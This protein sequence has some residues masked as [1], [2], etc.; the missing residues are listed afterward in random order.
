MVAFSSRLLRS[1]S[2]SLVTESNR[3]QGNAAGQLP[4]AQSPARLFSSR[5]RAASKLLPPLL[6]SCCISQQ[7]GNSNQIQ[8]KQ[9]RQKLG[10]V[11][12]HSLSLSLPLL[13]TFYSPPPFFCLLP[14]PMQPAG[15][16]APCLLLLLHLLLLLQPTRGRAMRLGAE[17][18]GH[19]RLPGNCLAPMGKSSSCSLA[20]VVAFP[21]WAPQGILLAPRYSNPQ[22]A[23]WVREQVKISE[24]KFH[25][26]LYS[27]SYKG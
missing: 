25:L 9:H 27:A 7:R 1:P 17:A 23:Y 5:G 21:S 18:G 24:L 4:P 13:F 26:F 2:N 6:L 20:F 12:F 22:S 8:S 11:F 14:Q 16:K 19:F 10:F 3:L 15:A